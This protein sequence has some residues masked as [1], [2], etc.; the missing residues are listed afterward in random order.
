M[1]C[2]ETYKSA[3]G[4]WLFPEEV[5]EKNDKFYLKKDN[6]EVHR[7]PIESMSK[8]K[9]NVVDPEN[10]IQKYGADTARLFMLSD[11]PPERDINWSLAGING[12]WKFTQKFWRTVMN[13]YNVFKIDLENKPQDFDQLSINFRK[14]IHKYLKLITESI[15][16]FQ[17]N[18]AVAK[19]HELTNELGSFNPN[20]SVQ[21]WSKKEA[22]IILLR[23]AEPMMPH[24]A[25]EC[26]RHVGYK[27]SIIE[28]EWPLYDNDL[29]VE[30]EALIIIQINGKKKAELKVASNTSEFDIYK[31]ALNIQNIKNIITDEK[32]IKK[33]IFIP[34]KI[35]NIVI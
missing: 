1:V 29:I 32:E 24:L 14:K 28:A 12:A 19:I 16:S 10:I 6:V 30:N 8:S 2:H 13:S 31:A 33:R 11:S 9:K 21:S 20:N 22:L 18:V 7:G 4:N 34:N 15:E 35:L 27:N 3:S 23:V 17:M 26:W 5:Y 25:E